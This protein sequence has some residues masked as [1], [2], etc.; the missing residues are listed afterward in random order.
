MTEGIRITSV[1]VNGDL[2]IEV[3]RVDATQV[4]STRASLEECIA[5][6]SSAGPEPHF[7]VDSGLLASRP[8]LARVLSS[9]SFSII[10]AGEDNKKLPRLLEALDEIYRKKVHRRAALV[11]VGGGVLC[12]MAGL[13]AN[14]YFRGIRVEH[15]PTSLLAMVDAAVGGKVAVNHPRQK[16]LIGSFYHPAK[17]TVCLESLR[18]LPHEHY[19][20]AFGEIL[21]IAMVDGSSMFWDLAASS[22]ESRGSMAWLEK[23]VMHC[24]R[25]KFELLGENC[26]ER[27]LVRELNFGHSIAH[28]IEDQTN[29]RVSHG[30][31]VAMGIAVASLVSRRRGFLAERDHERIQRCLSN[32]GLPNR[33]P[34]HVADSLKP[35]LDRLLLQRGGSTLHY[36]VP[37]TCTSVSV[38]DEIR[39]LEVVAAA[40]E[41]EEIA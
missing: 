8:E 2:R 30:E 20:A 16:N 34:C 41:L 15:I 10:P 24:I 23:V 1:G 27:S 7:L 21:K 38:I 40:R 5:E 13:L 29:F 18:T 14:L 4:V 37:T 39:P 35:H 3:R 26:F 17:V 6:R 36:V 25:S 32:L 11:S 12:D 28:P 19:V 33:L 31:A 9:A 22:K